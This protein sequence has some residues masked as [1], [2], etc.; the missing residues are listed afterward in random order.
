MI[1]ALA[2]R[3]V[4]FLDTVKRSNCGPSYKNQVPQ[5]AEPQLLQRVNQFTRHG[6]IGDYCFKM[7]TRWRDPTVERTEANYLG[8]Q[9]QGLALLPPHR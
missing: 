7:I 5:V 1:T 9:G 2:N 3:G 4:P 6:P 8:R